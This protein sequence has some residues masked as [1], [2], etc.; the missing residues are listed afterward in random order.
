MN[1]TRLLRWVITNA[2]F[3]WLLYAAYIQNSNGAQNVMAFYICFG[4][5]VALCTLFEPVRVELRKKPMP[6]WLM[7]LDMSFDMLVTGFLV[8]HD[9]PGY[10]LAY[11]MTNIM[12]QAAY[13]SQP[14]NPSPD[15][16]QA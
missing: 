16:L 4:V 6:T 15:E 12:I 5:V 10:G 8:W 2:I 9:R 13:K 3:C 14:Q 7:H 11:L 1:N